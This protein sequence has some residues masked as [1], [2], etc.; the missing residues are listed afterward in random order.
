MASSLNPETSLIIDA[1][2]SIAFLATST[3]LV[4][5]EIFGLL[6]CSQSPSIIG[7]TLSISSLM[8]TGSEPGRVLS[9]P[10]SMIS[11]PFRIISNPLEIACSTEACLEGPWNESG[12]AFRIPIIPGLSA[13]RRREKGRE[14]LAIRQPMTDGFIRAHA[15][16]ICMSE[17]ENNESMGGHDVVGGEANIS[18]AHLE[19]AERLALRMN[20][21]DKPAI[22][23]ML[24]SRAKWGAGII[25]VSLL[26]WWLLISSGS[27]DMEVGASKFLGLD[28]NEVALLV[29]ALAFLYSV[30]GDFSRELGSL[31]PSI[32]SGVMIIFVALYVGEPIVTALL[33][34]S[35]SL[36]DGVWR[37][38]R[39]S[40]VSLGVI[41]GGHLIVDASLLLWLRRFLEAHEEIELTPP[42]RAS[43]SSQP[44]VLDD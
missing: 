39:L 41:Y 12:V 40:L 22:F 3:F 21:F 5:I 37:T 24:S 35:L 28:F 4:S 14:V 26:F 16:G 43:E 31:V 32:I 7:I 13:S 18:E 17:L 29:M 1:P 42:N 23:N 30:F 33:S 6:A 15:Q 19:L 25:T 8:V 27:D 11:E 34:D 10:M 36:E 38:G 20:I 2:A 44:L 9:P